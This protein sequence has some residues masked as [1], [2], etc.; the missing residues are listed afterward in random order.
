MEFT[1]ALR[2]DVLPHFALAKWN[3]EAGVTQERKEMGLYVMALIAKTIGAVTDETEDNV[4]ANMDAEADALL[5]E[6][7][8]E[9]DVCHSEEWLCDCH[10]CQ[11]EGLRAGR[12]ADLMA[13]GYSRREADREVRGGEKAATSKEGES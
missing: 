10:I 4:Y 13:Q 1:E 2:D 5:A 12:V 3:A 6:D 8:E 9:D 7:E 11:R